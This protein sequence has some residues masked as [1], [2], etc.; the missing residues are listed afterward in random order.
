MMK[1][2][3]RDTAELYGLLDRGMI[4]CGMKADLNLI[5]F[6]KLQ[7]RLR[8]WPSIFPVARAG[9]CNAQTDMWRRSS[10]AR[11]PCVRARLPRRAPGEWCAGN[12]RRHRLG[13]PDNR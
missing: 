6:D 8:R 9:C 12:S 4:R 10:P 11:S 2:L 3:T 5:D 7:L 1:R 13:L